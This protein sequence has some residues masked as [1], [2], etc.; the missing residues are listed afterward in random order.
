[1]DCDD[2]FGTDELLV[3][4]EPGNVCAIVAE[5]IKAIRRADNIDRLKL[6]AGKEKRLIKN[7]VCCLV[8][9]SKSWYYKRREMEWRSRQLIA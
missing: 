9:V 8:S 1:M 6:K 7:I 3:T 2:E 4:P 5:L